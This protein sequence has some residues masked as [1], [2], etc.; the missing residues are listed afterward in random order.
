VA[1]LLIDRLNGAL[2][3]FADTRQIK[4]SAIADINSDR[5]FS[6]TLFGSFAVKERPDFFRA[7]L[8]VTNP[9][10]SAA[11]PPIPQPSAPQRWMEAADS[12]PHLDDALVY[13]GK[14]EDWFNAY[15]TLECLMMWHGNNEAA[16]F[17]LGWQPKASLELLK[18]TASLFRH[19]EKKFGK[20]KNPMD[21]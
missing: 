2:S 10:G 6:K 20:P 15:K 17:S 14:P 11:A 5:K 19:A 9:D 1:T 21:G 16:V 3:A 8:T 7:V 13:F 12:N 4:L 18:R